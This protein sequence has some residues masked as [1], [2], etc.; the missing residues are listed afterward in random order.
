MLD[1]FKHCPRSFTELLSLP[2]QQRRHMSRTAYT[3]DGYPDYDRKPHHRARFSWLLS[4]LGIALGAIIA[5]ILGWLVILIFVAIFP[6]YAAGMWR[7]TQG[8]LQWMFFP[9]GL[10]TPFFWLLAVIL[11]S[12]IIVGFAYAKDLSGLIVGSW[13]LAVVLIL[14]MVSICIG[15]SFTN[16][17][18]GSDFYLTSTTFK[19]KDVNK[20]PDMLSKYAKNGALEVKVEQGDLPTSWVPRV[21]SATGALNVMKK[22]GDAVNNTQLM[23]DSVTYLY[24]EG[25]SGVW[26]AI[27]N[28]VNQQEIYGIASWNG[29]GDRV[30]TCQFTGKYELHKAF[31][32]MYGKNL[33]NSVAGAY[34]SFYYNQSD[35]W[36]YCDGNEPVIVI[37]GIQLGHT[38]M[39]SVDQSGGVVTIHGSASGVPALELHT[40]VKPGDFPGPVYAQ[41]LV[42]SQRDSLDWSAGY[43][44][45]VNEHFGFDVTD[46]ES[47]S[48]NN[49]NYL[50]KSEADGR[51]YWVTPL[52][53]QS[54]DSQTLIAYS[55]IPADEVTSPK[56]NPQTVYVLN[57]DD[58]RVVNLDN[59]MA[60]VTD[61]VRD[62][63]P[64]FF[65]GTNPGKIVEFLPVSDTQWQ[66]FAEVQGRVKYRI[67]VNVDARVTP[68]VIDVDSNQAVTH[69]TDTGGSTTSPSG[70]TGCNNPSSLTDTQLANCLAELAKELQSRNGAVGS[71]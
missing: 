12:I 49:S 45:S 16:N 67:D 37:P 2:S 53:P 32:G 7:D 21:A 34:P 6:D 36:G 22:T 1:F 5:C 11:V 4:P 41:R 23:D 51:L 47:Q 48:G 62:A 15:K 19:V 68:R 70:A 26:T 46:V 52:K 42:D 64:G 30:T 39:R 27:R 58:T 17:I 55:M 25:D 14:L 28:G 35:M 65:T 20:L 31:D 54:T 10:P 8:M 56:L 40:N 66:V 69:G 71:K 43:W 50:M 59:L 13:F 63:N 3:I 9:G 38:D 33:W 29:T 60:R 18:L 24:G 57:E 61:A 44:Q